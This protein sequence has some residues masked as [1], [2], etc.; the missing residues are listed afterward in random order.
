M[1][2]MF[3]LELITKSIIKY[4]FAIILSSKRKNCAAMSRDINIPKKHLYEVYKDNKT[5]AKQIK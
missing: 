1:A 3:Q 4:V 2:N 5:N